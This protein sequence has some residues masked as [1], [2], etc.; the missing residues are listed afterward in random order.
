MIVFPLGTL[1]FGRETTMPTLALRNTLLVSSWVA[2]L[3]LVVACGGNGGG[4]IGSQNAFCSGCQVA[5]STTTAG[6]K[7]SRMTRSL[8]FTSRVWKRCETLRCRKFL[9]S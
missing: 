8:R 2:M 5:Y 4:G 9:R 3:F 1:A 7:N 6:Q